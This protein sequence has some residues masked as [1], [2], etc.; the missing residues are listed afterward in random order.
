MPSS[1]PGNNKN[2]RKEVRQTLKSFASSLHAFQ[3]DLSFFAALS[4]CSAAPCR[5]H[6][7]GAGR[8]VRSRNQ[9][10]VYPADAAALVADTPVRA[11]ALPEQQQC[12]GHFVSPAIILCLVV[13]ALLTAFW[14]LYEFSVLLHGLELARSGRP[15]QLP[16]LLRMRW[17]TSGTRFFRRTGRS[18]Y[19][20]PCSSPS[21]AFPDLQLHHPVCR[22]G[23]PSG[24]TARHHTLSCAVSGDR[25]TAGSIV[26][27]LCAGAA[28]ICPGAPQP[29]AG[30]PRERRV[31]AAANFPHSAA[32]AALESRQSSVRAAWPCAYWHRCTRSFWA[33]GSRTPLPWWRCP[34]PACWSRCRSSS[35]CSTAPSPLRS[36]ASCFLLYR[37]LREGDAVPEDTRMGSPS[38]RR[39]VACWPL[40]WSASRW[41]QSAFP[42]FILPCRRMMSCAPCWAAR[43]PSSRH[44]AAIR[45]LHRR[46]PCPPFSWPSTTTATGPSWMCR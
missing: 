21:P 44:T 32:S 39:A 23:V 36:A 18:S 28:P 34:A 40:R 38:V 27:L 12:F 17:W 4:R 31:R 45:R 8:T 41:S 2:P 3:P 43:L 7:A 30:R 19:T 5:G 11:R 15:V 22:T 46:T 26:P 9:P 25:G 1:R 33:S 6:P 42:L 20:A 37:R 13:I 10:A 35:S 24:R 16:A 29:V 14:A